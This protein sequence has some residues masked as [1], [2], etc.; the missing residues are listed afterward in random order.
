MKEIKRQMLKYKNI[1]IKLSE[2]GGFV[3]KDVEC[4]Y[5]VIAPPHQCVYTAECTFGISFALTAEEAYEGIKKII[6]NRLGSSS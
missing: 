2:D 5:Q 4:D 1:E 3:C 6:D